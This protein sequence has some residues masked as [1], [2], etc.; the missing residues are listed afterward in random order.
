MNE[1]GEVK[2]I[3]LGD[4]N[5]KKSSSG[6]G[7]DMGAYVKIE[8]NPSLRRTKF[9]TVLIPWSRIQKVIVFGS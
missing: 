5:T 8:L 7:F 9:N 3:Y 6:K 1:L 2:V 4:N